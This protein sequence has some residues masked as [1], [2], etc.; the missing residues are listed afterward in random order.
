MGM[1][2]RQKFFL[3]IAGILAAMAFL[4]ARTNGPSFEGQTQKATDEKREEAKSLWDKNCLESKGLKA[5]IV[6]RVTG[7]MGTDITYRYDFNNI[8][9]AQY[10]AGGRPFYK[11]FCGRGTVTGHSTCVHPDVQ[12]PHHYTGVFNHQAYEDVGKPSFQLELEEDPDSGRI[13]Y[14]FWTPMSEDYPIDTV[15]STP[16]GS[17]SGKEIVNFPRISIGDLGEGG[18]ERVTVNVQDSVIYLHHIKD[19][20]E[21][22]VAKGERCIQG[23]QVYKAESRY[24]PTSVDLRWFIRL[25]EE[26]PDIDVELDPCR[27]GWRPEKDKNPAAVMARIASPEGTKCLFKFTLYDVSAEPGYCMNAG[28]E[29]EPD[30]EFVYDKDI[31]S[32]PYAMTAEDGQT[33]QVIESL[34]PMEYCGVQVLPHDYG[35]YG[36]LK[37]EVNVC[38]TWS[39]AHEKNGKK[40]YI[41]IP[42]DDNGN[43]IADKTLWDKNGAPAETDRDRIPVGDG[44]LGDGLSLYEE[45]RGF[46]TKGKWTATDPDAKDL[47]VC[48]DSELING[49]CFE[50]VTGLSLHEINEGEF[51]SR[52]SRVVNFN[53]GTA[54][55]VDQHGLFVEYGGI[56]GDDEDDKMEADGVTRALRDPPR[57]PGDVLKVMISS[58]AG[59]TTVPHELGHCVGI[60]HHGDG[61]R[62]ITR[63]EVEHSLNPEASSEVL[64]AMTYIGDED[65]YYLAVWQGENSGSSECFMRYHSANFYQRADGKIYIYPPRDERGSWLCDSQEGTGYNDKQY[66]EKVLS[67]ERLGKTYQFTQVYPMCGDAKRGDC[68]HQIHVSD[69]HD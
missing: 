66:V 67:A 52:S 21:Y 33:V 11:S 16:G 40:W 60:L 63:W 59:A 69:K 68:R 9:L 27:P 4:F 29:T 8:Q 50:E 58:W 42:R 14:Q 12:S 32:P 57:S 15:I 61:N 5:E 1:T 6:A 22:S 24:C 55:L 2:G 54:H 30:L 48:F 56:S 65:R 31:F 28:R 19:T 25:D 23:H 18:R 35:A 64:E 47:F 26:E 51:L 43:H 20:R 45:Y 38:G 62:Y 13:F 17:R 39:M 7:G 36:K 10:D 37:V 46:E 41:D 34:D 44:S 49:G 3:S 53:D